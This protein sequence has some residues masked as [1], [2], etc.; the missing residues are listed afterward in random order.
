MLQK[1]IFI[2]KSSKLYIRLYL[3][4]DCKNQLY[5]DIIIIDNQPPMTIYIYLYAYF[6][7]E[8]HCL[9]SSLYAFFT[10]NYQPFHSFIYACNPP[11]T[12]NSFTLLSTYSS[13]SRQL[14]ISV[15]TL[16]LKMSLIAYTL[17]KSRE[18]RNI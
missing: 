5:R 6:K 14:F 8:P 18:I 4:Q 16:T 2:Y 15:L 10:I 13:S 9:H 12:A 3:S 17:S 7:D 1:F 11:L